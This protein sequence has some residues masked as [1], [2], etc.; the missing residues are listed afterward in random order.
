MS[1]SLAAISAFLWQG[2]M[3][4]EKM[5]IAWGLGTSAY[6]I[7]GAYN[8][9][10]KGVGIFDKWFN[11]PSR[12]SR[13]NGNIAVDHYNHMKEDIGYLG[14]L[15][16][17]AYRFSVSW[18]RILPDCTGKVNQAGVKFY[19]DMID[20]IIKNGAVPVLTMYHWDLPQ[21]CHDRYQS[22]M[23]KDIVQDFTDYA[24]VLF[25]NFGD[26][27]QYFLTLNEPSAQCHHKNLAHASVVQHARKNYANK[28]FKFGMPLIVAWGEPL[29]N[30][31]AD[32]DA[33]DRF[34]THQTKWNW[35]PLVDGDYPEMMKKDAV[36]GKY[37]PT[38]TE[39]EK[40]MLKGTMDFAAVNY[41]SASY[42]FNAPGRGL[43]GD[44][45][46]TQ[47]RDGVVLGP[48]SGTSWQ[49]V[50]PVGIRGLLNW[51]NK[52]FKMEIVVAECGTSVPNEANMTIA[53]AVDDKFRQ[54]FFEGITEH[55]S[56]AV[57]EDKL[58]VSMFLGWALLDNFEWITYDE[59]FGVIGVDRSTPK[60]TRYIKNSARFLQKYF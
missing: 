21:A 10:G 51:I 52:T 13:P 37:F 33:Q 12:A 8:V 17:T 32:L 44:F 3:A 7:E 27:V 41:Y 4:Q 43:E 30:S 49:T 39:E 34:L 20:E 47:V 55:F 15:G 60:M 58:P 24:D 25:K 11:D 5:N 57:R 50:Y 38:Y 42:I 36:I 29:T 14:E 1:L 31:Q 16:A 26:R 40:K 48:V 46:G 59:H 35:G 6:Q 19:S 54:S 22:W 18:P 28:K 53:Q 45:D 23:S 9:D 2:A 56:K